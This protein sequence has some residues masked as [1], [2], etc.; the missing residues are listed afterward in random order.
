MIYLI[1]TR[2]TKPNRIETLEDSKGR[3]YHIEYARWV[4]GNANSRKHSDFVSKGRTNLEFYKNNQW[5]MREDSEAFFMDESGQDRHRIRVTKNYIQPMVEQ[6]RGNAE[7]MRFDIKVFNISPMA[8]S[9]RDKALSRLKN[10]EFGAQ[11][12]PGFRGYL[13][14]NG[15]PVGQSQQ[16]TEEKFNNSYTDEYVVAGNKLMRSVAELNDL[17]GFKGQLALDLSC[18]GIGIMRPEP[19]AGDW[20]FK[21][22]SP[23][24]WGY[25]TSAQDDTLKDSEFFWEWDMMSPTTIY[26]QF[27]HKL[28]HKERAAIEAHVAQGIAKNYTTGKF[29]DTHGKVPV[30]RAVWRDLLVDEFGYVTDEYGQRILAR[31]N[32]IEPG[33][34][35]PKYSRKDVL[36]VEQLNTHQKK[37][38]RGSNTAFL[39]VDN[40]RFA[41]FIPSEAVSVSSVHKYKDI[42]L[43][44]GILPYQEE[45]LY[46]PTNMTPPYKVGIWSYVDGEI[47]SPV[48]VAINPQRMINRFMSVM[49]NRLNTA[50]GSG[51]IYDRD[52]IGQDDEDE[53]TAKIHRGEAAGV[54]ARGR[55]VQNIVGKYDGMPY[56]TVVAFNNLI[57]TMKMSMEESTG[58]NE[59]LKGN[60]QNPDQLVGVMQLMI[61][62]GS[63]IQ[64]P[65]YKA[66][67]DI[68]KGCYQSILT[69]GKRYYIDH[70]IDLDDYVGLEGA[71]VIR[72][73]K[74]MRLENLRA[75]IQRSIDPQTER[76]Y[77]DGELFKWLQFGLID[78]PTV[79]SLIG[80]ASYEEAV[81]ALRSYQQGLVSRQ[82]MARAQSEVDQAQRMN[83]TQQMAEVAYGEQIR[84][85][86][87]EDLNKEADRQVKRDAN[88]VKNIP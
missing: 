44:S 2:Q 26:E 72:L 67:S 39:Y 4:L 41:T 74:E 46:R 60:T 19:Y 27:P 63:I 68:Y 30:Y 22:V 6:Y 80:K 42:L 83:A 77:V 16:E 79:G 88:A 47:L 38:L 25:D 13:N 70:D 35:E 65:F 40:W 52:M 51:T 73:S 87:R 76:L 20:V 69:A 84:Q 12:N 54:N 5:I 75:T 8:R 18:Y 1:S 37:V 23:D 7:R 66:L 56:Q 33:E 17:D 36:P 49:E 11:L 43:D 29:H 14:D 86:T 59:G 81:M 10:Y 61:Q 58:V 48:D 78:Q 55:G 21:R 57:E 15:I 45:D 31:I 50:G 82:R 62:R 28:E 71:Q 64:E 3:D 85:E 24:Q 34:E 32:Y 53:F 9:R